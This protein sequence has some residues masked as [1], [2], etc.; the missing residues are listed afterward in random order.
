LLEFKPG[1]GYNG[2]RFID[3]KKRAKQAGLLLILFLSGI[4]ILT[5]L[6]FGWWSIL[7]D[8]GILVL[9]I[10]LGKLSKRD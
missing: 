4:F 6:A 2:K 1:R 7:V 10:W 8:V 9:L 3:P 5:T